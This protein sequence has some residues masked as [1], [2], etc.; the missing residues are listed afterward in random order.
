MT[1]NTGRGHC[2]TPDALFDYASRMWGPFDLDAAAAPWNAK[3]ET[4][5]TEEGKFTKG[6]LVL[7]DGCSGSQRRRGRLAQRPHRSDGQRGELGQQHL[8]FAIGL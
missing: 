7:H 1:I 6:N 4:Y 8:R 5:Y 3:A 2:S